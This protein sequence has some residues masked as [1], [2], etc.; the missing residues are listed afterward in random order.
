[1]E[2]LKKKLTGDKKKAGVNGREDISQL[3]GR[4]DGSGSLRS[5][6]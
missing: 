1:M 5:Y 3:Y 4:Y 2:W 6:F